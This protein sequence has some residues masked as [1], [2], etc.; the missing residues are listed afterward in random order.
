MEAGH[1]S[2]AGSRRALPDTLEE[3]LAG[4]RAELDAG[5]NPTV[6][7]RTL[8]SWVGALRRGYWVNWQIRQG[9]TKAGLQ[10]NPNFQHVYLDVLLQFSS[11]TPPPQPLNEGTV[12]AIDIDPT[13][14]IS[15]LPSATRG[16]VSVPPSATLA[17]VVTEMLTKD[18]SQ[19]PVMP[20]E[21]DVKG[22]VS[23]EV[24]G[25][26]LALKASAATAQDCMDVHYEVAASSP[27]FEA[28]D[29]IVQ[30]EYVLVRGDD[31]R[32]TGIVTTADLSLQFRELGEPFLLLGEIEN[33]IRM[34]ISG[35]NF[36]AAELERSKDAD[37]DSAR[38]VLS[39]S[40][41]TFGEYIRLIENDG[42]WAKLSLALDRPRFVNELHAI[43]RI[44]NDVMHFDPDGIPDEDTARLRIFG[45]MLESLHQLKR[46]PAPTPQ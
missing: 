16:V 46:P 27:L 32:I 18:F 11:V 14:R 12:D 4:I 29:T 33:H 39:V 37:D 7:V 28:I 13:F 8:L 31:R 44:R 38:E 40:D 1:W 23:W 20:N 22:T 25:R 2:R 24:I 3:R 43:R 15:R 17:E 35:A 9:L 19:L 42:A 6:S 41:L 26:R 30:N 34:L 45:R 21:R 36:T 10:T 5:A